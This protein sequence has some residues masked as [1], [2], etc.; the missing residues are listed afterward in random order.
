[1]VVGAYRYGI[2]YPGL[3]KPFSLAAERPSAPGQEKPASSKIEEAIKSR[4]QRLGY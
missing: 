2:D 1:M 3:K 4:L